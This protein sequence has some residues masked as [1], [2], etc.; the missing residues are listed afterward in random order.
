MPN[1]IAHPAAS[2]PFTKTGMIFSALV[3]GSIAP[4]FWYAFK[5]G[6]DFFSY[7]L[8]GLF[9]YDLPVGLVLLWLFQTFAK[10]P[11]LALLPVG[12][13]RR[14]FGYAQGFSF[15][16]WKR[17]GNVTLSLLVGSVTHIIWDSFTHDYGWTVQRFPILSTPVGG[18][19]LYDLLQNLSTVV[20]IAI[21][22]YWFF[23][24]LPT[25]PKGQQMP[26]HLSKKAGLTLL[27]LTAVTL[28]TVEGTIL[29]S[30]FMETV[31]NL[32]SHYRLLGSLRI[33]AVFI[34]LF[35][36]GVYCLIWTVLFHRTTRQ[37]AGPK[38]E[39][40]A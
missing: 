1:P 26:M 17:F 33:S 19:P 39:S 29:Y 21:L 13:Q 30:R 32:H 38:P 35:F 14:F 31:Q 4:D 9:L 10:W 7:S 20:G 23:R 40:P 15:N 37:V 34:V 27:G 25:T 36:L 6:S 8:P 5:V 2:I 12:M 24:W 22:V 16:P 18:A 28:V 11:L 3:I